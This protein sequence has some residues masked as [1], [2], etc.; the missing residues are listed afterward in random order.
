LLA[1]VREFEQGVEPLDQRATQLKDAH[2]P[3]P[4]PDVMLQLT[5]LQRQ[6]EALL[7]QLIITVPQRLQPA[8]AQRVRAHVNDY[9]KRRMKLRSSPVT[10][11][12]SAGWLPCPG[13]LCPGTTE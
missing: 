4:S 6:K 13:G 11:P 8:G 10:P 3:N 7:D 5:E 1:L 9:V 12:G 2:W